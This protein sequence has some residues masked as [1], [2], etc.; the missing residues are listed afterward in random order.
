M[1]QNKRLPRV[2]HGLVNFGTQS[3]LFARELQRRGYEAISVT[4]PDPYKRLT[5]IKLKHG[6]ILPVKLFRHLSNRWLLFRC[7]FKYDI[8]HFYYGTS[9]FPKN[10][11]LR[12]Y[13]LFGKKVIMEYLGSDIQG[14]DVSVRKYRWTNVTHMVRPGEGR[15]NDATIA[16]RIEF[17]KKYIDKTLVCAPV[18][19]EF[20]PDSEVLA[21]AIDLDTTSFVPMPA[22]DGTF[23]IMHAPTHRG[24]KGTAFI[25]KAIDELRAEG[26]SIDFDLVEGVRHDELMERYRAC[27]I[28]IDQIMGGWYGTATIEAMGIGRPVV[29]SIRES[30][31]QYID[32]GNRIPAVHADPECIVE[33]L[34]GLLNKGYDE[35][36]KLGLESRKFV[37]EYH[38]VKKVT[39]KLVSI[40]ESVSSEEGK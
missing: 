25:I 14:Y 19:S 36:T 16:R 9:L 11:D 28:F 23:R 22:F 37:E 27:Q 8:F 21:L 38:C 33:V 26:F 12:F 30:Y 1:S 35:L 7:F 5:D 15:Q 31:F 39:D 40:Y 4:S 13:R 6:G 29:V 10:F 17:Q 34:R 3:G 24:F 18:Y 20:S 2:F 32:F